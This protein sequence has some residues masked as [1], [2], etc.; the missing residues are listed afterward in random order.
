[1]AVIVFDEHPHE[2]IRKV[3]VQIGEEWTERSTSSQWSPEDAREIAL[4]ILDSLA[5][6]STQ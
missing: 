4:E 6:P 3:K 2:P 1:M 5:P